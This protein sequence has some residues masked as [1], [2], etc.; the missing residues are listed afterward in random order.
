MAVIG[1]LTQFGVANWPIFYLCEW[2]ATI[3]FRKWDLNKE[4]N[5]SFPSTDIAKYELFVKGGFQVLLY[6][7]SFPLQI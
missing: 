1:S 5:V 2:T 3:A 6:K 7:C 4:K